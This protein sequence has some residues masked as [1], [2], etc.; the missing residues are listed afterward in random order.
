VRIGF[1]EK[2]LI[3]RARAAKGRWDPEVKLWFIR[4]ENIMGTAL[5]KNIV[6]DALPWK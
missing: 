6:L 1:A 4:Y 2:D 3:A 5:E